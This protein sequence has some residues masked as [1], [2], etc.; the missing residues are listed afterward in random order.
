MQTLLHDLGLQD[1]VLIK[2]TAIQY[3]SY[4]SALELAESLSDVVEEELKEKLAKSPVV[5]ALTDESTDI[6]N[7]KRLVLYTQIIDEEMKPST[8]FVTN[9]ELKQA[10]GEAIANVLVEEFDK[11]GVKPQK[12]MSLGSDGAS[13]MTGTK[14]DILFNKKAEVD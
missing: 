3:Q 14:T 2:E 4:F 10:T 9:V 1:I 8:H 7:H 5:S 12:I 6:S 13:V 11:R